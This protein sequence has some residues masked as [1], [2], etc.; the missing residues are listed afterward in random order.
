MQTPADILYITANYTNVKRKDSLDKC[1]Q[2]EIIF[3]C[4]SRLSRINAN[5]KSSIIK[6]RMNIEQTII[7]LTGVQGDINKVEVGV[8]CNYW[9]VDSMR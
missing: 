1:H 7:R 4:R 2:Q 3:Q 9:Q 8:R 6:E 5:I